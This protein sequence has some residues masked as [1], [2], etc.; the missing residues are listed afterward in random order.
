MRMV[1]DIY[2]ATTLSICSRWCEVSRM[3]YVRCNLPFED[4]T[5]MPRNRRPSIR[6][7]QIE[8]MRVGPIYLQRSAK[9]V[10]GVFDGGH[11]S[12]THPSPS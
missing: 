12:L 7:C 9:S 11:I 4:K 3:V 10:S 2:P 6:V 5:R 8:P 1:G